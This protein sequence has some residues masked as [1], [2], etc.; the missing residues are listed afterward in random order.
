MNM[1][2][3]QDFGTN[4]DGTPNGDYCHYCYQHGEFT[5]DVT[6]DGM[7]ETNLQYIDQWNADT[8]NN[9]TP[10]EARPMLCEFLSTLKRWKK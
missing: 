8:G 9:F 10:D 3:A 2:S 6:M 5:R 1:N 7:V 4:A